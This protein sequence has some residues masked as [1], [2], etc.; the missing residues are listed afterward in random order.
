MSGGLQEIFL[1]RYDIRQVGTFYPRTNLKRKYA[2]I[3]PFP[4][5]PLVFKLV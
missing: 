1:G 2:C 3:V 5:A 4:V